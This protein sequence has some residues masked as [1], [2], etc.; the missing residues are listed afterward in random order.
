MS[1]SRHSL[2]AEF[3]RS[4]VL[5]AMAEARTAATSLELLTDDSMWPL[6]KYREMLFVA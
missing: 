6:P 3:Q 4:R 5:P 2:L 1:N